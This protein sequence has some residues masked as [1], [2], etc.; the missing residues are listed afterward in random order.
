MFYNQRG[1]IM[2]LKAAKYK[3]FTLVAMVGLGL[4]ADHI[5]SVELV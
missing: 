1:V 3:I 4:E 2:G 5:Q